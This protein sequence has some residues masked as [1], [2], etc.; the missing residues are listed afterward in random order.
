M[1]WCLFAPPSF[2]RLEGTRQLAQA[3]S[4]RFGWLMFRPRTTI[5]EVSPISASRP[6][7][8]TPLRALLAAAAISL[9]A[10]G[11]G[12]GLATPTG[13]AVP[14]ATAGGTIPVAIRVSGTGT[15]ERDS[16]FTSICS[17][18][19]VAQESFSLPETTVPYSPGMG[20]ISLG[21]LT[22]PLAVSGQANCLGGSVPV[23]NTC[24]GTTAPVSFVLFLGQP[25]V[26]D[27]AAVCPGN[28]G[29][30]AIWIADSVSS[31]GGLKCKFPA[32]ANPGQPFASPSPLAGAGQLPGLSGLTPT[33]PVPSIPSPSG[34]PCSI[35]AGSTFSFAGTQVTGECFGI[36]ICRDT[37]TL[38]LVVRFLSAT[39]APSISPTP[40]G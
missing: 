12:N 39:A 32:P 35:K 24:G 11:G 19:S 18:T 15:A 1:N 16:T 31:Q 23:A 20:E 29:I 8:E 26:L 22:I 25:T 33:I 34:P 2:H 17:G 5:R 7:D 30:G 3:L 13:S 38:N 21:V 4:G 10:C 40:S 6:A 36:V 37:G 9:A 14:S 27:S 28:P